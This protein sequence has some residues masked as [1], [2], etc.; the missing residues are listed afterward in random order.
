MVVV[1]DRLRGDLTSEED[2]VWREEE[3]PLE[4]FVR[5]GMVDFENLLKN[6]ESLRDSGGL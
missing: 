5:N 1:G 2:L 6:E 4:E 3:A